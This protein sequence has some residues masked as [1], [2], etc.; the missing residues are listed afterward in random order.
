MNSNRGKKNQNK[1]NPKPKNISW[2]EPCGMSVSHKVWHSA[3]LQDH[4]QKKWKGQ[5]IYFI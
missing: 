4:F 3:A 5:I 1:Q 2:F